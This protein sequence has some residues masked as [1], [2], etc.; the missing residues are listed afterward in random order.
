[1]STKRKKKNSNYKQAEKPIEKTVVQETNADDEKAIKIMRI[2][3]GILLVIAILMAIVVFVPPHGALTSELTGHD[4]NEH[5]DAMRVRVDVN[6]DSNKPA[7]NVQYEIV[8]KATDGEIIGTSTGTILM[9]FPGGTRH[10]EKFIDLDKA[11]D[12]G[13]VEVNINGYLV[14][15]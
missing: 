14:G 1:M 2:A 8:V 7:F 13:D 15:E 5:G 3:I 4:F 12:T 9:M 11:V 6:N 10:L